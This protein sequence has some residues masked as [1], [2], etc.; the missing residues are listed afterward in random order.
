MAIIRSVQRIS[1]ASENQD[2]SDEFFVTGRVLN[3]TDEL[4][5]STR[6]PIDVVREKIGSHTGEG[7][8][9]GFGSFPVDEGSSGVTDG[10]VR[11]TQWESDNFSTKTSGR[12][13]VTVSLAD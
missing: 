11:E 7:V 13:N 3:S 4:P 12:K 10:D 8:G 2:D 9:G 1:A 6:S 5:S